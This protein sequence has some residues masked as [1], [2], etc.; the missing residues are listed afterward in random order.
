M[1]GGDVRPSYLLDCVAEQ[2]LAEVRFNDV[3]VFR[4]AG[5]QT[6]SISVRL[7]PF[8][9]SSGNIVSVRLRSWD[10]PAPAPKFQASLYRMMAEDEITP[11]AQL[12]FRPEMHRIEK[13]G[14]TEIFRHTSTFRDDF[15]EW[16]FE[17][18]L[19]Y[20]EA[21]DRP[22][23]IEGVERLHAS[24]AASDGEAF[25]EQSRLK[26][27]EQ[28]RSLGKDPATE[29]ER[30]R[31]WIGGL[32]KLAKFQVEPL[33]PESLAIEGVAGG[34]LVMVRSPKGEPALRGTLDGEKF[35]FDI[36]MM[37]EGERWVAAR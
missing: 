15:G 30:Q 8:A 35:M 14:F 12:R 3:P 26:L 13:D 37:R 5:K 9:L 6:H 28:A 11:I 21:R 32:L 25:V 7:N 10:P 33:E 20:D 29:I 34:R 1:S 22:A 19:P 2:V 18:A 31:K 17:K 36:M 24:L 27:S 23:L 4:S 16:A